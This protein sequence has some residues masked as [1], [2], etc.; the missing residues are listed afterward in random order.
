M[1]EQKPFEEAT[2]T[3]K[4]KET[5]N[6]V[7]TEYGYHIIQVLDHEQAH[8]KTFDEVKAQLSDE[9]RKQRVNQNLQDMMDRVQA[10]L[11]KEPPEWVR[12]ILEQ[13]LLDRCRKRSV[14]G[15]NIYRRLSLD[16]SL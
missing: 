4:P 5:S 14:F 1:P 11:K 7:K 12:R 3:L 2:F 15:K 13:P 6:V 16:L 10:A 9:Y 8:L